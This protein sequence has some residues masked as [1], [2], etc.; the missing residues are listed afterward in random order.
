MFLASAD[1]T[2]INDVT[3][4]TPYGTTEIDHVIVSRYGMFV[5]ET[6][7]MSGWIFGDETRRKWAQVLHR[8]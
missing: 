3:I 2:D 7:N 8:G 4:E 6:K 1:Y 5:I